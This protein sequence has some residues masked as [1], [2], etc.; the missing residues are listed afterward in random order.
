MQVLTVLA[1]PNEVYGLISRFSQFPKLRRTFVIISS[2]IMNCRDPPP[3]RKIQYVILSSQHIRDGKRMD[4][5]VTQMAH[6]SD[7]FTDLLSNKAI[8]SSLRPLVS[9]L[10]EVVYIQ[11]TLQSEISSSSP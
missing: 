2:F 11:V 9:F 3:S 5:R 1:E 4:V 7:L 8:N 6:Y 10:D